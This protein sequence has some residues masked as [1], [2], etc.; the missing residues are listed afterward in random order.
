MWL[1]LE[2]KL[3]R[4]DMS[5]Y[6]DNFVDLTQDDRVSMMVSNGFVI[7]PSIPPFCDDYHR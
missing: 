6:T 1:A 7:S 4:H 2:L 3:S 5:Y